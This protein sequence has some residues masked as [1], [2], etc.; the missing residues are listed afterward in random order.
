L[1]IE[2]VT[3]LGLTESYQPAKED[4]PSYQRY[5]ERYGHS[6]VWELEAVEPAILQGIVEKAIDAVIN[7]NS[8]NHEVSQEKTD[9]AHV[10]AVRKII[11]E[12][13]TAQIG[14]R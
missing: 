11:R 5:F 7:R 4:S 14:R 10:A 13:L 6:K 3:E 9:L 12:T 2:Q 8:F 1:T